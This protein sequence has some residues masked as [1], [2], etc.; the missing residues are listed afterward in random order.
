MIVNGEG[1]L[2]S[3]IWLIGEAPGA[4]EAIEGRPFVGGSGQLLSSL[5]KE[6]SIKREDCYVDNV[7]Q[8]RPPANDFSTF[9][10]KGMPTLELVQ[11]WTR[12]QRLV[13][14][15]KP[16]VVVALGDEALHALTRKRGIMNWR[17]SVLSLDGIKIVPTIHPAM[18]LREFKSSRMI[19]FDLRKAKRES[20]RDE[21]P[22]SYR[23]TFLLEPHF[24]GALKILNDLKSK[25]KIAFDIETAGKQILCIGFAWS[26]EEAACIPIFFGERSWWSQ[27]EELEIV[28]GIRELFKTKGIK[29]IAQNAQFDMTYLKDLWGIDVD[30]WMDT[31]IA[32]HCLYPEFPKR[33]AF[34]TSIFTERN[35][36]KHMVGK[37]GVEVG[38][39][40][41]Q[42]WE[43][44][45][46]DC[47]STWECANEI[48]RELNEFGTY[49]FYINHS[50]RLIKPLM[51]MQRRGIKIDL[52]KREAIRDN[53]ERDLKEMQARLNE[54]VGHELNVL[55][56]K[57]MKDFLYQELGLPRKYNRN[58]GNLTADED[59]IN[60][61]AK[62][63]SSPIFSLI[64]DI[65]GTKKLLST[66]ILAPLD[67][68]GRM[69]C[70]YGI[71]GTVT[72]R[73]SSRES[74]YGSGTD[75]QNIPRGEIVRGIF[76]PDEGM[77]FINADLSQ[78]E[79]R[80]VAYLSGDYQLQSLFE[81]PV[82]DIHRFNASRCFCKPLKEVTEK[83]RQLAK[84]L[85]H[86]ANYG[87]GAKKFSALTGFSE[88]RSRQ[89]LNQYFALYPGVK[90]WHRRVEEQIYKTKMM[91]TPL[92]RKRMF[93]GRLGPDLV[94]EAIAYVPQSLVSDILNL[95]LVEAYRALPP[96]W[97]FLL[98][99]HDSVLAQVPIE[100][101][102]EH[103]WKFFK[104]FFEIGIEVNGKR[105]KI[106]V[107]IKTGPNWGSL[108]ELVID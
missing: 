90:V 51:E 89:L 108:K 5:L 41:L 106:P 52:P 59:A 29:F 7:I 17:G 8:T 78:A 93:F 43:Y 24:D 16:K 11:G 76:I 63:N 32:F 83:E 31:M 100:T 79:A 81:N 68:D 75:L 107:D 45:C 19:V 98:Q 56:P 23:D 92:G 94:R 1:S 55:S 57:Q 64:L 97:E 74:V 12:L 18:A 42:L 102:P 73:L 35:Y 2:G 14:E 38:A 86:A 65:R 72:G 105:M 4:Q 99:V 101:P 30:L 6:A 34:L 82:G 80:A 88:D 27:E 33:L 20:E 71:T 91:E 70:S 39:T 104:H 44:N 48:Y 96:Q 9:Y 28:R 36:Y 47:V 85:V 15:N 40:P 46:L 49:Q 103:I 61:L 25:D 66:Y 50:H 95:G 77:V 69:R 10:V 87:T 3:K 67:K 60:D 54:A 13:E 22:S 21:W 58:S 62:K 84:T 53:L 37:G 26:K